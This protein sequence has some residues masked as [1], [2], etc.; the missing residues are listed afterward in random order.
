MHAWLRTADALEKGDGDG[1]GLRLAGPPAAH[2]RMR[3]CV[4]N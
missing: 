4:V 3:S 1:G 2:A